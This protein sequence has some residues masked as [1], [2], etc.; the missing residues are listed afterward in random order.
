MIG[1]TSG[2]KYLGHVEVP[3]HIIPRKWNPKH[4]YVQCENTQMQNPLDKLLWYCELE[5]LR[6]D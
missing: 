1:M 2:A 5:T 6:K 4:D 3:R